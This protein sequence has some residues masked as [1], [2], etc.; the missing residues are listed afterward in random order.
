MTRESESAEPVDEV[1]RRLGDGETITEQP[2]RR[3]VLLAE[4]SDISITWTRYASGERGPDLHVHREHTDA[5]YVLEGE[6]TFALG[7]EAAQ[8]RVSAGG[9]VAVPPNV[10]HSF[11]NESGADA[12][13][14]NLHAPDKGFAAYL[15]ALRDGED[16]AFDSFDPPADG[17][18]PAAEA[19]AT[20]PGEGER[21]VS[22]NR[23]FLL[24]GV[25]PDLCFTEFVLDGR[26]E[27]PDPHHHDRQVDS[28]YVLEGELDLRVEGSLQRAGPNTLA[29]VPRGVRHTFAHSG[30]GKARVLNVHAPDGGF[31]DY[32]RRSSG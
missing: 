30:I 2:Q 9:F 6:L 24:K 29:S 26:F 7:P 21:L 4:R 1:L 10:V 15:R 31:A 19:I 14:L 25:L 20:G 13:W 22:A 16:A 28:F 32:L 18:L 27:G 3:V 23:V 12:C 5:F 17:G 11:A 8:I